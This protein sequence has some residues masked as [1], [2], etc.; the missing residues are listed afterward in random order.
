MND[1]ETPKDYPNVDII[2]EDQE[3]A[4]NI[5]TQHSKPLLVSKEEFYGQPDS[6]YVRVS[7]NELLQG[8]NFTVR[9]ELIYA[10]EPDQEVPDEIMKLGAFV[11]GML[12]LS[13]AFPSK[14]FEVGMQAQSNDLINDLDGLSDEQKALLHGMPQGRA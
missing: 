13:M 4:D 2:V 6:I 10:L 5:Q 7:W 12:E 9:N 1:N 8:F 11:R 14:C 3:D